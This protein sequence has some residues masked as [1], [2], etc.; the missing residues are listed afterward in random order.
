MILKPL[1]H[2]CLE[3]VLN[4]KKHKVSESKT[5]DYKW[6]LTIEDTYPNSTESRR[7]FLRDICSFANSDG[8]DLIIGVK[9]QKGIPVL[10]DGMSIEDIDAFKLLCDSLITDG[11]EPSVSYDIATVPVQHDSHVII[12]RVDKNPVNG[13]YRVCFKNENRFYGRQS[14]RKYELGLSDLRS[15]FNYS[16]KVKSELEAIREKSVRS[17]YKKRGPIEDELS[18]TKLIIHLVPSLPSEESPLNNLALI[19]KHLIPLTFEDGRVETTFNFDGFLSKTTTAS[20]LV[21]SYLQL[22]SNG[23]VEIVDGHLFDRLPNKKINATHLEHVLYSS[24]T[25][26]YFH[27]IANAYSTFPVYCYVTF[28][29]VKG[30]TIDEVSANPSSHPIER[31]VLFFDPIIFNQHILSGQSYSL[32]IPLFETIWRSFGLVRPSTMD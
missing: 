16:V 25:T 15:R 11:I 32:F 21:S 20:G 12:I 19:K 1:H 7:E 9:E 14:S 2:I 30:F 28:L 22:Y 24:M 17:I 31:E 4:L 18:D 23:V 5:L 6:I 10:I 8:G 3:D 26:H 29:N 13:P 27:Y